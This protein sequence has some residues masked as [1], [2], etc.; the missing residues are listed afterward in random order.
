[1]NNTKLDENAKIINTDN[2]G[3]VWKK[4]S[5]E[6]KTYYSGVVAGRDVF[7]FVNESSNQKAPSFSFKY[8]EDRGQ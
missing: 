5:K 6:G 1:M 8:R 2:A 7:M 4:M 3:A